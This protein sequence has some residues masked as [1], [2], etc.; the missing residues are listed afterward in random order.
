MQIPGDLRYT[1]EHEWARADDG[2]VVVG[3]TDYA[4]SQMGDV[5]H[6]DLPATGDAVTAGNPV[7]EI[8]STKSVSE[9]YAP[10]A[11]TIVAVND[12]FGDAPELINTD[13]YGD[14][15]LFAIEPDDASAV[16]ELLDAEGYRAVVDAA[17]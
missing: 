11:G 3:V 8:E 12:R 10:V 16:S 17:S 6:V 14:G 9:I 1:A 15:W 13:P 7:A 2:R 5:V 4:Q